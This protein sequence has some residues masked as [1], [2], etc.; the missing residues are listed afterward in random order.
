MEP[1]LAFPL[2]IPPRGRLQ[3]LHGQL[4]AA[5]MDGRLHAGQPL[6]STRALAQALGVSRNTVVAA[7]ERL[8]SEGYL[9]VRQGAGYTVAGV[10]PAR[11]EATPVASGGD[12]RLAPRWREASAPGPMSAAPVRLDLRVGVPDLSRFPFETWRRLSAQALRGLSRAPAL[13]DAPEGRRVLRE[14]IAGHVSFARAVSCRAEDIVV[15]NGAQQAFDLLARILVTPGRSVL[16]M[17]DPG[18]PSLRAAFEAA[19]AVV[20]PVPVDAEG[21]MVD[22]LP[23]ETRIIYVTPSHQYPLGMA[24]SPGRRQALLAF[25]RTHGAVVIEDDYDGEF[26]YGGRALDALQTLDRDGVVFYVGTFSKSLFPA[27]RLG[28][29]V[30][31]PWACPA[32]AKARRFSDWHG[33]VLAQDTLARFIAEGHLARHVRKMRRLYEERRQALLDG[34]ARHAAGRALPLAA[35]AG[36]HLS[37]RLIDPLEAASVVRACA[38]Q[39]MRI[40]ALADAAISQPAPNGVMFGL[41]ALSA[42]RMDEAARVLGRVLDA[43]MDQRAG[44]GR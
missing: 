34:L 19:G 3:A 24:M 20:V 8:L 30:A 35:E 10:V 6:P 11:R 22:R 9:G 25:A 16:A 43:A 5:I 26:R 39:G 15:T 28:Y 2:D 17:E 13:Y 12:R 31:P 33:D 40:E 14:A 23:P 7:Y 41:G 1:E 37:A 29:V 36:L 44:A 32:L 21:L 4:R 18:Y 38:A 27:L 42:T